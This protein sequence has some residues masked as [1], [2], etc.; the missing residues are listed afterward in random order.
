M[1]DLALDLAG[2]SSGPPPDVDTAFGIDFVVS[3][4]PNDHAGNIAPL[5]TR[6]Q[7]FDVSALPNNSIAIIRFAFAAFQ[8]SGDGAGYVG[9]FG[10]QLALR[11]DAGDLAANINSNSAVALGVG[12]T[13]PTTLFTWDVS[14]PDAN[15]VR[16]TMTSSVAE[17]LFVTWRWA[18]SFVGSGGNPIGPF[19]P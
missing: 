9:S 12:G 3:D 6:D 1:T 19:P 5:G 16:I 14:T 13:V 7:D 18:L 17:T 4:G 2:M 8:T 11:N 15:T 10:V